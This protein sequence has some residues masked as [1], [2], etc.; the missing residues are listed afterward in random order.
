MAKINETFI[1]VNNQEHLREL[2]ALDGFYNNSSLILSEPFLSKYGNNA[3]FVSE[4]WLSEYY[5][6]ETEIEPINFDFE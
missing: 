5:P 6:I 3:Y 2:K 4:K 1:V